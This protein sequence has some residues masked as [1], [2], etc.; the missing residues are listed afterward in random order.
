M[1]GGSIIAEN[2]VLTAAHCCYELQTSKFRIGHGNVALADLE[3]YSV[4]KVYVH[5]DYNDSTIDNDI[6]II[7]IKNSFKEKAISVAN[8][9][10]DSG[11]CT[12]YGWGVT[13]NYNHNPSSVLMKVDIG[14][15]SQNQC[16]E[17]YTS[18]LTKN[19]ICASGPNKDSCQ[20]DSGGPMVCDKKITGIVSWGPQE[21]ASEDP[22][23]YTKASN[24]DI[25]DYL[26]WTVPNSATNLN[27]NYILIA[28]LAIFLDK[29]IKN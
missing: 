10:S 14:L 21:C 12:V 20:G 16:K 13:S 18:G 4:S 11:S 29:L 15:I 8:T 9:T 7:K 23:V 25:S 2:L 27:L 22:G 1:C 24:Y 26:R 19:M 5:K 17:F 3:Y 28:I 6:C